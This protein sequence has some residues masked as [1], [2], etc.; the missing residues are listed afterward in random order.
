VD[1]F[2]ARRVILGGYILAA[3]AT[4][5]FPWVAQVTEDRIRDMSFALFLHVVRRLS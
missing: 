2:Q 1:R 4:A 5:T 3:L